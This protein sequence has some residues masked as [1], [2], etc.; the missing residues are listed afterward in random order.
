MEQSPAWRA[1]RFS[2]CQESSHILWNLKVHNHIH[3]CP[4]P[5]FI[6]SQIDLVYASSSHFLKTHF[7]IVLATFLILPIVYTVNLSP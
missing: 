3:N 6:L 4:P 1:N 7:I 2:S 5:V